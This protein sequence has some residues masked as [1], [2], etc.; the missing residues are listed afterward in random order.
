MAGMAGFQERA[1]QMITS[2]RVRDAFDHRSSETRRADSSG[3][4]FQPLAQIGKLSAAK[5][6][7]GE[8]I[9]GDGPI[10]DALE[11]REC[12]AAQVHIAAF[13]CFQ[14]CRRGR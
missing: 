7:G 1:L 12:V 9:E 5:C 10:R 13:Q 6:L 14:E 2:G 8:G 3:L 4:P 11:H